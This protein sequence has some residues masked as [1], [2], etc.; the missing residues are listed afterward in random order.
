MAI[1]PENRSLTAAAIDAACA[2]LADAEASDDAALRASSFGHECD[3]YLWMRLRWSFDRKPVEPR[4]RRIFDNGHDREARIVAY[5][6]AAGM[7]V[8]DRDPETGNQWRVRLADGALTGSCD[9]IVTGVPEAP[10]VRHLLEIKTMKSARWK[11][12]R[13]KGVRSSHP[14][15]WV[16]MQVYMRG[17]GLTRALFV[18]ECQDTKEIEAER[19]HYDDLASAGLEAR[20]V[21]IFA[22][23]VAPE[24]IGKPGA[25]PC[26]MCEASEVCHG[27][28]MPRR[29]CRTCIAVDA[30]IGGPWHCRRHDRPAGEAC[31][32]HLYQPSLVAGEQVDADMNRNL[33]TYRMPDGSTWTDGMV[34]R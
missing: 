13:A 16:Q 29:T 8:M 31:D 11:A 20:A 27:A 17:L 6:K 30:R 7:Q 9:G 28:M 18:S 25:W 15:Y 1:L 32:Q 5:I 2:A 21:R 24:R 26:S 14:E 12:W 33:I 23:H 10:V 34:A 3:R 19:V 4:I 22:A